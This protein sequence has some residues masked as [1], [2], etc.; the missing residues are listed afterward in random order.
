[1]AKVAIQLG[2][3]VEAIDDA[4]A[5]L[6]ADVARDALARKVSARFVS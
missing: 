4:C 5:R 2:R 1:V 3:A 6:A